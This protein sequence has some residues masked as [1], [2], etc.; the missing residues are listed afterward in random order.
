MNELFIDAV[1][2]VWQRKVADRK[3]A[4]IGTSNVLI[5]LN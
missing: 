5:D 2:I 4:R 1:E 3:G